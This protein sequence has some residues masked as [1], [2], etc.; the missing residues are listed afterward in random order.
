MCLCNWK[1]KYSIPKI[2]KHQMHI[3]TFQKQGVST[4]TVIS[5]RNI[6]YSIGFS[7]QSAAAWNQKQSR[8]VPDTAMPEQA[9]F[10]V[11]AEF[12][13]PAPHGPGQD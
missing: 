11:G 2:T 10:S 9:R 1:E 12:E 13:A 3:H 7:T 8:I 5:H 4:L 6:L